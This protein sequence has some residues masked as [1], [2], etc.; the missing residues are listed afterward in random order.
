MR[1]YGHYCAAAKALDVLGDRW[2][3]LVIRE[4]LLQDGAR[5]ADLHR[6]LPG[7]SPNLL[8][9]RLKLLE[10]H[11]L[12]QRTDVPPPVSATLYRLTDAGREV[13]PV[14]RALVRFGARYMAE[15]V[16]SATFR[17]HWLAFPITELL[18]DA[19]PSSGPVVVE[20][21]T[22]D[23]PTFVVIDGTVTVSESA[24]A[25]IPALT[26]GGDAQLVL[27]VLTRQLEPDVARQLGLHIAGDVTAVQR[28]TFRGP[29]ITDPPKEIT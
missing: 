22:G 28:L 3:L 25:A 21:R 14:I 23:R 26:L 18:A 19:A 1:T 7:I 10:T 9:D 29:P 12:V 27:G 24:P 16:G 15:P 4:L 6:G 5:Y 8:A 13:E 17:S 20:V 2:T 11:G